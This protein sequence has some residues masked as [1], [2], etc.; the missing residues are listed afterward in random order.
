MRSAQSRKVPH[1]L[2]LMMPTDNTLQH[3][4]RLIDQAL[5]LADKLDLTDVAI[6]IDGARSRLASVVESELRERRAP[7]IPEV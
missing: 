3:L 5:T 2:G 1:L 4:T 6:S 7:W